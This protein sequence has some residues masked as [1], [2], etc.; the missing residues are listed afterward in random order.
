M[1]S[2]RL[3]LRRWRT[4]STNLRP[5]SRGEIMTKKFV[6]MPNGQ[7]RIRRGIRFTQKE[8]NYLMNLTE[9]SNITFSEAVR[10]CVNKQIESKKN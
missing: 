4:I 8:F 7:P 1:R 2:K 3:L 5:T 10:V 9:S 6:R